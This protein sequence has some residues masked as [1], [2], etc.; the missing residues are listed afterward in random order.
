MNSKRMS[1]LLLLIQVFISLCDAN[2]DKVHNV[3][4]IDENAVRFVNDLREPIIN[5]HKNG[6]MHLVHLVLLSIFFAIFSALT[7]YLCSKYMQR[8]KA[9]FG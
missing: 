6:T 9:S 4:L 8:K 5:D 3:R 7:C 1:V 2:A